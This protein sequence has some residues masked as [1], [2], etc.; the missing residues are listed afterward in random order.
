MIQSFKDGETQELFENLSN[1]RWNA[2]AKVALR[3]LDQIDAAQNLNDLRVPPGNQ[4]EALKK[5]RARQHSIRINDQYR[6]Y[7][8]WK[9]D[10]AQQVEITD[11]HSTA[12]QADGR[13]LSMIIKRPTSGWEFR[14]VTPSP[15]EMLQEEFLGPLGITKNALAMKIRVPA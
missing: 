10:G 9:S 2:I 7:F 12:N 3:K 8:I 11:Y 5:D 13:R 4:L 1:K 15:G 6:I 14:R